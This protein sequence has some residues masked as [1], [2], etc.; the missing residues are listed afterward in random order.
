[1]IRGSRYPVIWPNRELELVS[2]PN[3]LGLVWLNTLEASPRSWKRKRSL[4]RKFLE[5]AMFQ[6]SYPGPRRT[7]RPSFPGRWTP[8]G[9]LGKHD[10]LNQFRRV[11][12]TPA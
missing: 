1:M 9:T 10:V 11:L 7:P 3:V 8:A 5:A 2:E 6:F 4:N 12:V